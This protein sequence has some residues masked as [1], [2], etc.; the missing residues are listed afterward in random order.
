MGNRSPTVVHLISITVYSTLLLL[1]RFGDG[2]WQISRCITCRVYRG[3]ST[4]EDVEIPFLPPLR[5]TMMTV[6]SWSR[7]HLST[8]SQSVPGA[9]ASGSFDAGNVI[10]RMNWQA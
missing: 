3:Q 6:Q 1:L 4:F 9:N 8:H 7:V 5:G 10:P 2:P